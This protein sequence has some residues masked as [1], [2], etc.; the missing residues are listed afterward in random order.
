MLFGHKEK[1]NDFKHRWH[2]KVR[3]KKIQIDAQ[4]LLRGLKKLPEHLPSAPLQVK[5]KLWIDF[6]QSFYTIFLVCAP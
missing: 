6:I 5:V 4:L 1:I 3:R 2:E